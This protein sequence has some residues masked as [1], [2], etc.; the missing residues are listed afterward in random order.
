[1]HFAP[2]SNI[3]PAQNKKEFDSIRAGAPGAGRLQM[4]RTK[5]ERK[6]RRRRMAAA[7]GLAVAAISPAAAADLGSQCC[8]DLESRIAELEATTARKGNRK[9]SLSITGYIAQEITIWDDGV[10]RNAYIH[11]MGPT[12]A[13]NIRFLGQAKIAPGWN[14]GYLMRIQ[15][16]TGNA[17]SGGAGAIDQNNAGR[18]DNLNIQMSLW[19]LQSDSLGKLSVGR[20]AHAAKSA[21]M[22][23]DLSGTQILDNYT[24]LA[25]FPHFRLRDANGALSNLTWGQ[26]GFCYTQGVP[27]GGDCNGIVMNG[28]RYDTPTFGGFSFSASWGDDDFWEVGA[29]YTGEMAGF[30]MAFGIGYT[31]MRDEVTTGAVAVL[32]SKQSDFFQTGGYVQHIGTGL[33]LHGAYGREFNNDTLLASGH[34]QL[35]SEQWYVKGGI[36]WNWTGLGATILYG[37]YGAY[38]DQLGPAALAAGATSSTLERFGGGIAQEFDAAATTVYLKYQRYEA[39]VDGI[40]DDFKAAD[41]LSVGALVNF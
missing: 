26:L 7:V 3:V 20:Q 29:R 31:E 10:E 23:T 5:S 6:T 17:F 39:D 33:F 1:M 36:R 16:L 30:K 35:D 34:T 25:G 13:S 37:T 15:D 2:H 24:F 8:A 40:A 28:V 12:Q 41:F 18:N 22:F 27:L 14:A 38:L 19:Y 32:T 4:E 21:A 11:G 9:V